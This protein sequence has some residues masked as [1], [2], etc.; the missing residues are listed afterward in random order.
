MRL[1]I[2]V[3]AGL[4]LAAC[5]TGPTA[6]APASEAG[7]PVMY[8]VTADGG[9]VSNANGEFAMQAADMAEA[10]CQKTGRSMRVTGITA[11]RMSLIF[12]CVAK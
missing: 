6:P 12:T 9:R 11:E 7:R 4:S 3:I 5:A 2:L 8:D 1:F 10:H